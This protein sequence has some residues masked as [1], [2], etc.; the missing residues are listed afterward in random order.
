MK[1]PLSCPQHLKG[2]L[3]S[4]KDRWARY[5]LIC[6]W[7]ADGHSV[8]DMG[9]ALELAAQSV[10]YYL[11]RAPRASSLKPLA[12]PRH[13]RSPLPARPPAEERSI[14]QERYLFV[15]DARADGYSF[16]T[17]ASALGLATVGSPK[18]ILSRPEPWPGGPSFH[19]IEG[20]AWPPDYWNGYLFSSA[21]KAARKVWL[22]DAIERGFSVE[23]LG[24]RAGNFTELRSVACWTNLAMSVPVDYVPREMRDAGLADAHPVPLVGRRRE[25]GAFVSCHVFASAEVWRRWEQVQLATGSNYTCVQVDL[26]NPCSLSAIYD[27]VQEHRIPPP[28][29]TVTSHA[30]GHS[31]AVWT[32]G[33]P[34][35]RYPTARRAPLE[36]LQDA[37][38]YLTSALRGDSAYTQTMSLNPDYC[39]D[40]PGYTVHYWRAGPGLELGEILDYR[41]KGWHRRPPKV[42]DALGRNDEMFQT[43]CKWAGRALAE[44]PN[45]DLW[46]MSLTVNA[47][48][49]HP[50][51]RREVAGIVASVER[52][53]AEWLAR[54]HAPEWLAKQAARGRAGG[55]ASASARRA[56]TRERDARI[57]AGHLRGD[58][59]RHLASV[60]G[61]KNPSQA[62]RIVKR[63]MPPLL[64]ANTG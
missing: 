63:D 10:R 56:A 31:H 8:A 1:T 5:D 23:V 2:L 22:R 62:Y 34:V 36:M 37:S 39:A 58:S 15:Q 4:Q 57:V 6:R 45:A 41:P 35:H 3:S 53:R 7:A 32:L 11:A 29:W 59:Y 60:H 42:S 46:A 50:V 21:D 20:L 12:A 55:L 61:L 26:D 43:L 54:G 33:V 18:A 16:T 47:D 40:H 19:E 64:V 13:L 17:I 24:R 49:P 14:R 28:A 27:A 52:Y 38:V 30:T 25:D 51:P 48:F 44:S 9:D